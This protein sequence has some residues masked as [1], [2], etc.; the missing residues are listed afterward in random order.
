VTY[1]FTNIDN[2]GDALALFDTARVNNR[3]SFAP[4]WSGALSTTYSV[5][6]TRDL[7]LRISLEDKYN[8]S[9]NT[10]SN[11]D[12]RK[13]QGAF[14]LLNA[15][16]GIGAPDDS[17]AVEAWGA[18]LADKYYYAVA[19]DTPFQFDTIHSYLGSPRTFGVTA[20]VRFK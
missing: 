16:V 10:G 17:W 15:R 18:N 8:S 19:F 20:R 9:Y 3:L 14:G 12:P 2:Y 1:A 7:G 11:L 5:A 6:F 13:I 4:L